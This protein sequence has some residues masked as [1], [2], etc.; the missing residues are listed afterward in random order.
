MELWEREVQREEDWVRDEHV[1]E[2]LRSLEEMKEKLGVAKAAR[3]ELW[4]ELRCQNEVVM[5][6]EC[7]VEGSVVMDP[8]RGRG[9]SARKTVSFREPD[10]GEPGSN[11]IAPE[12]LETVPEGPE[13]ENWAEEVEAVVEGVVE[14]MVEEVVQGEVTGDVSE[15]LESVVWE[16]WWEELCETNGRLPWVPNKWAQCVKG[17]GWMREVWGTWSEFMGELRGSQEPEEKKR[18]VA[19]AREWFYHQLGSVRDQLW[20]TGAEY[21]KYK[22][23]MITYGVG[24]MLFSVGAWK[25]AWEHVW[26]YGAWVKEV[27]EVRNFRRWALEAAANLPGTEQFEMGKAKVEELLQDQGWPNEEE[28]RRIVRMFGL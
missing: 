9:R 1:R 4:E 2:R 28:D 10:N 11:N 22:R 20:Q 12:G 15:G 7:K 3:A 25:L 19:M 18:V 16:D 17:N 21:S 13:V 6:L 5:A 26:K 24:E 8:G 27:W 23:G 14:A